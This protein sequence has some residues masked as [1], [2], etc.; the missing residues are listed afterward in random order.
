MAKRR[1]TGWEWERGESLGTWREGQLLWIG[2]SSLRWPGVSFGGLASRVLLVATFSL[3][4]CWWVGSSCS[5]PLR[6]W[7]VM[8]P[9]LVSDFGYFAPMSGVLSCWGLGSVLRSTN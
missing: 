5:S 1:L 6:C 8:G 2:E 3:S 9:V 7:S 4:V